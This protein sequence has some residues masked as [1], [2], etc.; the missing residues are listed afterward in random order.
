M[1]QQ[2]ETANLPSGNSDD[3]LPDN[4]TRTAEDAVAT[5]CESEWYSVLGVGRQ[6]SHAE[7]KQARLEAIRTARAHGDPHEEA[8]VN[9]AFDVL[10]KTPERA[11]YDLYGHADMTLIRQ[12]VWLGGESAARRP[13]TLRRLG[14]SHVLTCAHSLEYLKP[15]LSAAGIVHKT[16]DVEDSDDQDLRQ[17]F[18]DAAEFV[19]KG[20]EAG[21]VLV[22]CQY[23]V[24]RSPSVLASYLMASEGLGDV[25]ALLDL[26]RR[27]PKVRPGA[28]FLAQLRQHG[29]VLGAR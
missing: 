12:S 29:E 28:G 11:R 26:Q 23:G 8:R 5:Q 9:A 1:E 13:E 4:I 2:G 21:G 16:L 19:A 22:H 15:S 18:G 10:G 14:I 3:V 24:S 27:R 6:S 17:H 20:R 25:E 7:V